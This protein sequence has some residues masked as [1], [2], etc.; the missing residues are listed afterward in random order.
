MAGRR[1]PAGKTSTT[2]YTLEAKI[3]WSVFGL[4]PVDGARYGFALSVSDNDAAG[5]ATQQSMVSSVS[6]RTLVNPTTWGTLILV[7]GGS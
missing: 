4:T 3:P 5:T 1:P 7:G 2:G 6:T